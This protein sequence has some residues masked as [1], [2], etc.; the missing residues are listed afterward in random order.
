LCHQRVI[1]FKN[2]QNFLFAH[3]FDGRVYYWEYCKTKPQLIE[4]LLNHNVIDICCSFYEVI[5]LTDNAIVFTTDLFFGLDFKELKSKAFN[6]E[7]VKAISC[8]LW[9]TLTLTESGCVYNWG[10]NNFGQLGVGDEADRRMPTPVILKDITEKISC[11][12]RHSLLLSRD[13]DIYTFGEKTCEQSVTEDKEFQTIPIKI[14]DL[15]DI[16]T[17]TESSQTK[18]LRENKF[19]DIATHSHY[20]ISIAL[21]VNGIYY[22]WDR[23]ESKPRE[24]HLKSFD[25]IF[26]EMLGITMK[27]IYIQSDNNF[28]PNNKYLNKFDEISE[29][30]SGSYGQVFEVKLKSNSELFAIKKF[31]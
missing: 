29:I 7:K 8:G 18:S 20:D 21:S 16:Q 19:I 28:I 9:H 27:A 4:S 3:T 14:N 13:G 2:T 22:V 15:T 11:G 25:E 10:R 5:A 6:G 17:K 23:F 24:T 12:L 26:A 1:D 30:G 31:R